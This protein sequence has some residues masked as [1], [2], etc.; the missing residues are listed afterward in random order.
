MWYI[1]ELSLA[2]SY[3]KTCDLV[4][5]R[6]LL[7]SQKHTYWCLFAI[8]EVTRSFPSASVFKQTSIFQQCL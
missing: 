8:I 7:A 5:L 1:T 2:T 3:L 6:L 4:P